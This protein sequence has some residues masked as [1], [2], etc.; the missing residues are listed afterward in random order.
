MDVVWTKLA[1]IFYHQ[2]RKTAGAE[3]LFEP[4]RDFCYLNME[5]KCK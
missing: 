5:S 3:N 1:T 4:D 2:F